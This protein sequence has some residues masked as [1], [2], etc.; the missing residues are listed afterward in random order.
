[1]PIQVHVWTTFNIHWIKKHARQILQN[2]SYIMYDFSVTN[3]KL[4]TYAMNKMSL[5]ASPP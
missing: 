2:I 5:T 1:M 4:L 3:S